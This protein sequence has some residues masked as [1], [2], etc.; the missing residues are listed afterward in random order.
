MLYLNSQ[1]FV[2]ATSF[3]QREGKKKKK[4]SWKYLFFDFFFEKELHLLQKTP[5]GNNGL[6]WKVLHSLEV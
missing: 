5:K 1:G 6:K 2:F 4:K 3:S